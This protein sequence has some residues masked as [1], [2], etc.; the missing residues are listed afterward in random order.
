MA[1][2][3]AWHELQEAFLVST[4]SPFAR[5]LRLPLLLV[6]LLLPILVLASLV[7]APSGIFAWALLLGLPW[8]YARRVQAARAS[9]H[10]AVLGEPPSAEEPALTFPARAGSL[11]A[12]R[13]AFRAAAL[14]DSRL[15]EVALRSVDRHDL[16]I[17][18]TRIFMAVQVLICLDRGEEGRA[19]QLAP[20]AL[21]T[22]SLPLDRRL[23]LMMIRASWQDT[24][25]LGAI[26]R[27]LFLADA[28]LHDLV[29]LCRIRIEELTRGEIVICLSPR[30]CR[31]VCIAAEE[32]GDERLATALAASSASQ[33]A[34]R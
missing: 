2:S 13:D 3:S 5:W 17:W 6:V 29:L 26:E 15:A 25:R 22:G 8:V 10:R 18:E 11:V 20:L 27:G 32:A 34:Y 12:L 4:S 28:A 30:L 23:G 31:Q 1:P 19:A 33:G 7:V 9:L 16:G 14:G 24:V 21:P